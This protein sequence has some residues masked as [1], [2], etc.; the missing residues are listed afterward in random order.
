MNQSDFKTAFAFFGLA[1]LIVAGSLIYANLNTRVAEP[2]SDAA[3]ETC[4]TSGLSR[5][6]TSTFPDTDYCQS[7]IAF[8][9]VLSGGV[10]KDGIPALTSPKY[11][12]LSAVAD[13]AGSG[14]GALL[15]ID[16]VKRFYPF[17]ILVSHEIVNDSIGDTD[18][19]VTFCPLCGSTI[20]F[21]RNVSGEVKEFGVSGF[22][23]ESNL[24]MYDRTNTPSLWSQARGEAVIGDQNGTALNIL[25]FQLLTLD[26][27][28]T[29]HPDAQ[30]LSEDTGYVRS[31]SSN[32]YGDY[33]Q[34]GSTLFPI[35]IDDQRYFAKE[36]FYIAPVEDNAKS[37]AIR[38][39][40]LEN[41]ES[42]TNNSLGLTISKSETSE[43]T[44][45][46]SDGNEIVGYYEMWFSWAQH[47][48][49]DG[50]VWAL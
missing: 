32:P 43:L 30:I 38:I 41:G 33:D 48:Q 46:D 8:S 7:S 39:G 28:R 35:S 21:D 26:E 6:L 1:V 14:Q 16:E 47:H 36:I 42:A 20:V 11:D 29:N 15:E 13:R 40:E 22:L 25:P 45:V 12:N 37:I 31:Y 5:V 49:D 4:D 3:T 17:N 2:E 18:Y 44:L 23:F 19:A 10:S 24:L 9:K 34:D 50:E 27:V